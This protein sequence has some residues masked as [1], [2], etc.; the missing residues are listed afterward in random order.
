MLKAAVTAA[1]APKVSMAN[2]AVPITNRKSLSSL[3][4]ALNYDTRSN[5]SC[6]D[7]AN[8]RNKLSEKEEGFPSN[9]IN[10]KREEEVG[11][12]LNE[13]DKYEAEIDIVCHLDLIS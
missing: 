12:N 5:E 13:G 2:T 8:S 3:Y 1:L 10:S 11:W 4:K 7:A 6:C 9:N